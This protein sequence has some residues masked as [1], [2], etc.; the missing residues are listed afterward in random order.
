MSFSLRKF[1]IGIGGFAVWLAALRE[2]PMT[3][4]F[5]VPVVTALWDIKRGGMGLIGGTVGGAMTWGGVVLFHLLDVWLFPVHSWDSEDFAVSPFV[6][7]AMPLFFAL[8]G[9]PLGFL[10]G[11]AVH[12]FAA[13][14]AR[15]WGKRT[16]GDG[17][18]QSLE[19]GVSS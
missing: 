12:H 9:I 14:Y 6:L 10:E 1:M 7:F 16:I 19:Q 15:L 13:F 3:A 5:A 4:L 2:F 8:F 17:G 11:V 18:S